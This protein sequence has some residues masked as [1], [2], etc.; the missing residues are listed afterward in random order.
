MTG[1]GARARAQKYVGEPK[2]ES[3]RSRGGAERRREGK[4]DACLRGAEEWRTKSRSERKRIPKGLRFSFFGARW[5]KGSERRAV[6]RRPS[7]GRSSDFVKSRVK[8][9]VR[10]IPRLLKALFHPIVRS[11]SNKR[12]SE[13]PAARRRI[14][15]FLSLSH[16]HTHTH[17]LSLSLSSPGPKV[18]HLRNACV[19]W[20]A[21][22]RS[23]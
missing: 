14:T 8:T 22:S 4:N 3:L 6:A 9:H 23:A 19:R 17:T 11:R 5:T 1:K 16:T 20:G 13:A 7:P 10:P 2:T 12:P 21:L 18:E 15:P